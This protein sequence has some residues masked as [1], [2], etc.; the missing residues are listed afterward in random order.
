MPTTPPPAVLPPPRPHPGCAHPGHAHSHLRSGA[1]LPPPS[2]A[3]PQ[4]VV[5]GGWGSLCHPTGPTHAAHGCPRPLPPPLFLLL[6][7]AHPRGAWHRYAGGRVGGV[8]GPAPPGPGPP[9]WLFARRAAVCVGRRGGARRRGPQG[10]VGW[11]P[12]PPVEA[13]PPPPASGLLPMTLSRAPSGQL[14]HLDTS[15]HPSL[16]DQPPRTT[17]PPHYPT[18]S[19]SPCARSPPPHGPAASPPPL[20]AFYPPGI[21]ASPPCPPLT[22]C[23]FSSELS[24]RRNQ[25]SF[26]R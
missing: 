19:P 14:L 22:L 24:W 17:A 13:A 11:G 21:R 10:G 12:A 26:T 3:P 20:C 5:A 7:G 15:P 1:A 6:A 23:A 4:I 16:P 8:W 18:S 25:I 2:P 9:P